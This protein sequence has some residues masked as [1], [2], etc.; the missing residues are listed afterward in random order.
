MTSTGDKAR[1][2]VLYEHLVLP[3]QIH[4]T[5]SDANDQ[6]LNYGLVQLLLNSFPVLRNA[7]DQTV[8]NRL[9][10]CLKATLILETT[11]GD[12]DSL[13]ASFTRLSHEDDP[14]RAWIALFIAGQ[15]AGL[16]I[17]KHP[18]EVIFEAFQASYQTMND[19]QA[20]HAL[21]QDFP[22]RAVAIPLEVFSSLSFHK[23]L[24]AFLEQATR[25]SFD[26]FAA[27]AQK[28]GWAIVETR[29][30]R[31]PALIS[32]MLMSL[33][34]G[35]GHSIECPRI[36]KKIRDEVILDTPEAPWRRTPFWLV[37]RVF[38][39][40]HLASLLGKS[41]DG[42]EGI[43]RVYYK[44]LIAV[45]LAKHLVACT[46]SIHPEK[47][48][49]LLAKLSRRLA[50]LES[51]REAAMGPLRLTYDAFFNGT[52]NYFVQ[53]IT[54]YKATLNAPSMP[55]GTMTE[56]REI[57]TQFTSLHDFERGLGLDSHLSPQARCTSISQEI[58]D[59]ISHAKILYIGD[60]LL[61]S[62]CLLRLFEQWVSMDK[63]AIDA[64]PGLIQY[65]PIFISSSLDVLCLQSRA[66]MGQLQQ[67]QQY[68]ESRAAQCD[69]GKGN[70]F[71][72]PTDLDSF[73]AQFIKATNTGAEMA[74]LGTIIDFESKMSRAATKAKLEKLMGDYD[75][76]T[77]DINTS[78]CTCSFLPDGTRDIRGC[79]RCYK[80]RRRNQLKISVHEDFLPSGREMA[81][82]RAAI[83][84]ELRLPAFLAKYR[85]AT[86]N[87][88]I[89][90]TDLLSS[91][92]QSKEKPSLKLNEMD[93][94]KSFQ[95]AGTTSTLILASIKKS[96][97][98]T[99]Y[100]I[101][102]IPV[103]P[104]Q[105][106]LPFA[107]QFSYYDTANNL[108]IS[109]LKSLA[110]NFERLLGSWLP[111]AHLIPDPYEQSTRL[112]STQA[113]TNPSSMRHSEKPTTDS[114]YESNTHGRS[115]ESSNCPEKGLNAIPEADDSAS[116]NSS[117]DKSGS[118]DRIRQP[119][120]M[121]LYSSKTN[122]SG[123]EVSGILSA[124]RQSYIVDLA[125]EMFRIVES[126][127]QE[128]L[129]RISNVLPDLLRAFSTQ[130]AY[131]AESQAYID[132]SYFVQ[133]NRY[134]IQGFFD[135]LLP[136]KEDESPN[137]H[138]DKAA[139]FERFF[140]GGDEDITA[141]TVDGPLDY[142]PTTQHDN[143]HEDFPEHEATSDPGMYYRFIQGSL[144]FEWLVSMLKREAT[145]TRATPDVMEEIKNVVLGTF[146]AEHRVTR[147][148]SSKEYSITFELFW[149]LQYLTPPEGTENP[150][151]VLKRFVTITGSE[152]ESQVATLEEYLSQ[153]WPT[154]SKYV[155]SLLHDILKGNQSADIITTLPDRTTIKAVIGEGRL[156]LTTVGTGDSVVEVGQQ[157]AWLGAALKHSSFETGI[158]HCT[159][160][161]RLIDSSTIENG[162]FQA[163]VVIS[164][165]IEEPQVH[166]EGQNDPCWFNLFRN[167][168]IVRG[169]PTLS[170]DENKTRHRQ[171]HLSDSRIIGNLADIY[172]RLNRYEEAE[173]LHRQALALWTKSLGESHSITLA[174]R[175][176]LAMILERQTKY[177][178]A[179][180]I[181]RSLVRRMK[182]QPEKTQHLRLASLSN[183]A[184]VYQTQG[185]HDLAAGLYHE[186]FRLLEKEM[187]ESASYTLYVLNRLGEMLL[188]RRKYERAEECFQEAFQ[189]Q[190]QLFPQYHPGTIVC[191]RN[192]ALALNHQGKGRFANNK[193][194][195]RVQ[196][197]TR[198]SKINKHT[199]GPIGIF[200]SWTISD[201]A[202]RMRFTQVIP[203]E[204][205]SPGI[206]DDDDLSDKYIETEIN[207]CKEERSDHP[208]SNR[209]RIMTTNGMHLHVERYLLN[210]DLFRS[211]PTYSTGGH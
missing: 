16:L 114:G 98:Q 31:S 22:D 61:M 6:D 3:S 179:K 116:L 56:I 93:Q 9:R 97:L 174:T 69:K 191:L 120:K 50:K 141:I 55:E 42:A 209:L 23:N 12:I 103:T 11:K 68:L 155:F 30:Y 95:L 5:A 70:I 21:T 15:N 172:R 194:Q 106:I 137:E 173:L 29:D 149:D 24:A 129:K 65:H 150:G 51:E 168:V 130:I 14:S 57:T 175:S 80:W 48:I 25:D 199:N 198:H 77:A 75:T 99:H 52:K 67:V 19:L 83:L 10:G 62:R 189:R 66:E 132:I 28:S 39:R 180:Q 138:V 36:R 124:E 193:I 167:P 72:N 136:L 35:L 151:T 44:F 211:V 53:V 208:D 101:K 184:L 123:S 163:N 89:L 148:A 18:S 33:L 100:R 158:S 131:K 76:L 84:F 183:L 107:P 160:E 188:Q 206:L 110:P 26:R 196:Q 142:P 204:F 195:E 13:A 170:H 71:S 190:E 146:P 147:R 102:R 91:D 128:S 135:D 20:T 125:S 92:I 139:I 122:Y 94:L 112:L 192:L 152:N 4:Y 203:K 40:R 197:M 115:L 2:E 162:P 1:L 59:Y 153:A 32:G 140:E 210:T 156:M 121:G 47:V 79:T 37:L 169:F 82:Q 144:A 117:I 49:T 34:E 187:G 159:P 176:N 58:T 45:A 202:V 133:K 64:Y 109:Q 38:I 54:E 108:W 43:S 96:F 87:L 111:H 178:E 127:D 181:L 165:K 81:G 154:S 113:P 46:T 41:Q 126:Y 88:I 86:W 177:K 164:F 17:H 157:F 186:F 143:D 171:Q 85:E 200:H 105:V 60:S 90:G 118:R 161:I 73:A 185:D 182:S 27:W 8:W 166:M 145:L 63:F 74:K 207:S 119:V 104:D 7:G 78:I 134:R 205:M 201:S